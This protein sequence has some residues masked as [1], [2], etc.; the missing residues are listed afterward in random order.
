MSIVRYERGKLPKTTKA[1]I[2]ELKAL[3]AMPDSEIDYSDLPPLDESFFK[4]A[5]PNPFYKPIKEAKTLRIDKD[6]L[7]WFMRKGKGY[8][9]KINE[10]LREAMMRELQHQAN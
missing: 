3:A 4:N 5:I 2:A 8:Q 10:A 6:V 1:D 9:T 7:N